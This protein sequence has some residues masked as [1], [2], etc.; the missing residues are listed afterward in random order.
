MDT[1]RKAIGER[2]RKTLRREAGFTLIELIVVIAIL[3][4]LA[5]ITV[6]TIANF[7][8]SSKSEAYKAESARIQA[9]VDGFYSAPGNSRFIGKRQFPVIGRGQT[10]QGSLTVRAG[11]TTVDYDDTQT[12]FAS[13]IGGASESPATWN[14]VGGTEG[15]TLTTS[16]WTDD[17][18]GE[19]EVESSSPDKFTSVTVV[20][21]GV[22]YQTDPRY[23]FIDFEVLVTDGLLDAVPESASPD[24]KPSSG[25]ATY[26]GSYAWYV[27]AN[28]KVQSLYRHLPSTLGFE[29]DVFP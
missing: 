21:G 24:N 28:G 25:T 16:T 23:F 29:T 12:P 1:T 5:A 7:L 17:A 3:G 6:P 9:A 26:T 13:T 18:D 20:R 14:P 10:T 4:V 2:V 15:S 8:S 11:T 22:S 19:R 27:D